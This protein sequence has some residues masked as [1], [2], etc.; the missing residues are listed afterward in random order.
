MSFNQQTVAGARFLKDI[1]Y[2]Q[3]DG[4]MFII[5]DSSD[6]RNILYQYASNGTQLKNMVWLPG[7]LTS[8]ATETLVIDQTTGDLFMVGNGLS[9][10][11]YAM[12]AFRF[13][14]NGTVAWTKVSTASG[15]STFPSGLTLYE[16]QEKLFFNG[17]TSGSFPGYSNQGQQDGFIAG[18]NYNGTYLWIKQS[19]TSQVDQMYD[20]TRYED[21]LIAGGRWNSVSSTNQFGFLASYN[22]NGTQQ[23]FSVFAFNS[24][25]NTI[26]IDQG[27]I[28]V[29]GVRQYSGLSYE[30]FWYTHNI[31]DGSFNSTI[32]WPAST[33][34]NFGSASSMIDP[35][36]QMK[37]IGSSYSTGS[38]S[39]IFTICQQNVSQRFPLT[40]NYLYD[41]AEDL[42]TRKIWIVGQQSSVG[43]LAI[44][45]SGALLASSC[46]QSSPVITSTVTTLTVS[47]SPSITQTTTTLPAS[48]SAVYSTL[49]TSS[50]VLTTTDSTILMVLTSTLSTASTQISSSQ[51]LESSMATATT[52]STATSVATTSTTSSGTSSTTTTSTTPSDTA[53]LVSTTS[54]TSTTSTITT[55]SDTAI[56]TTLDQVTSATTSP[57]VN[58]AST[59]SS[60]LTVTQLSIHTSDTSSAF[61]A[62]PNSGIVSASAFSSSGSQVQSMSQSNGLQFVLLSHSLSSLLTATT[63]GVY[64]SVNQDG[65]QVVSANGTSLTLLLAIIAGIIAFLIICLLLMLTYRRRTYRKKVTQVRA[66]A[67]ATSTT[68]VVAS[69]GSQATSTTMFTSTFAPTT[70]ILAIPVFLRLQA[71]F[72]FRL[73]NLLTVTGNGSLYF[74]DIL[75]KN[76]RQ[77]CGDQQVIVKVAADNLEAMSDRARNAFFQELVLMNLFKDQPQFIKLYGYSEVPACILMRYYPLGSLKSY[78]LGQSIIN[79][80]AYSKTQLVYIY[81]MLAAGYSFMHQKNIVH[82][83]IKPDNVLLDYSGNDR[84]MPIICDFGITQVFDTN[85]YKVKALQLSNVRGLSYVYAAP[86]LIVQFKSAFAE[87]LQSDRCKSMDVYAFSMLIYETL[88]RIY[89]YDK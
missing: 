65:N 83:D 15:G 86:E 78:M 67:N 20:L 60:L 22:V 23:W 19:G 61:A 6:N 76:A 31:I 55:P 32:Y 51:S 25:V 52:E 10:S 1:A 58:S 46:S 79:H 16:T 27:L 62:S 75:D 41:V 4:I 80:V 11:F 7:G 89:A 81:K 5:G 70:D 40:M 24:A 9:G 64:S 34:V 2:R 47:S 18:L 72:G 49:T 50:Q 87:G 36:N 77:L 68:V 84:L 74:G 43:A 71:G 8:S 21:R 37:I 63:S 44:E 42:N 45:N 3:S 39:V 29:N 17:H 38:S 26:F 66:S 48:S 85:A 12:T 54:T 88:N 35:L 56:T 53:T 82:F 59:P 57:Q 13:H 30:I 73:K 69:T 28:Q 14:P 33:G